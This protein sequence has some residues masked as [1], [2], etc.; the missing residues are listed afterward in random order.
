MTQHTVCYD[1]LLRKFSFAIY[2]E[3]N[4][5]NEKRV[6]IKLKYKYAI[7]EAITSADEES[8]DSLADHL[9]NKKPSRVSG[10]HGVKDLDL[11]TGNLR[12]GSTT[13]PVMRTS[14]TNLAATSAKSANVTPRELML[15][16]RR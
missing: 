11:K 14:L 4:E 15:N 13:S 10:S 3:R 12:V 16:I 2:N 9:C 6:K 8:N 1:K 7:E 5:I